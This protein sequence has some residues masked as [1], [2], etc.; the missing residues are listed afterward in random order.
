MTMRRDT[1]P[2]LA[3][4]EIRVADHRITVE[5]HCVEDAAITRDHAVTTAAV[6]S[7]ALRAVGLPSQIVY[8]AKS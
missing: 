8:G 5:G 4:V 2:P 1:T 6:I 7:E 3:P